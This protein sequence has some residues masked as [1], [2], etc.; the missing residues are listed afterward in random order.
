MQDE[1]LN[2]TS[3]AKETI[4]ETLAHPAELELMHMKLNKIRQEWPTYSAIQDGIRTKTAKLCELN[5]GVTPESIESIQ[6]LVKDEMDA[7]N[8]CCDRLEVSVN[9]IHQQEEGLHKDLR[10]LSTQFSN[11]KMKLK[12]CEDLM[13]AD[14]RL[15]EEFKTVAEVQAEY[16]T[17]QALLHPLL[18]RC[19]KLQDQ[20]GSANETL[21]LAKELRSVQKQNANVGGLLKKLATGINDTLN[22]RFN[23][24]IANIQRV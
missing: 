10:E 18:E 17:T 22:K 21:P 3:D 7:T 19:R 8:D 11:Y 16:N 23:E 4:S 14:D 5:Q 2:W 9:S 20:C 1:I 24:R 6:Q 13:A 12:P 15:A